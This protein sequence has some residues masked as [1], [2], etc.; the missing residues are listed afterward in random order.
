LCYGAED[1][2]A[3]IELESSG[4]WNDSLYLTYGRYGSGM[5]NSIGVQVI[6]ANYSL[7]ISSPYSDIVYSSS[8]SLDADFYE[9]RIE[10]SDVCLETCLLPSLND[11]SY[12]LRFVVENGTL[13]IDNVRYSIEEEV[14]A[15]ENA[16]ILIKDFENITI[17]GVYLIN[18][19][20]YFVDEDG[21]ELNYS[22]YKVDNISVEI[23]GSIARIIPD[24]GFTGK[25]YMFFRASDGYYETVSNVFSVSVEEALMNKFVINNNSGDPVASVDGEGNM[26]IK[27]VLVENNTLLIPGANSFIIQNSSGDNVAYFSSIGDLYLLG[28]ASDNSGLEGNGTKLEFRNSSDELVAFIDNK[29]NLKLRGRLNQNHTSP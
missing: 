22:T 27:G 28:E 23:N 16:P 6:Y 9:E 26:F 5:V 24:N 4:E 19:S 13:D 7:N 29:G 14:N 18:L 15:S 1:C 10:F 8:V 25:R 21:D 3:L 20:E 17:Y 2:C 11:S 12:V